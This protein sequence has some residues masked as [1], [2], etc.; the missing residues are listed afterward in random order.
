MVF[1]DVDAAA[2]LAPLEIVWPTVAAL[3][4][5]GVTNWS[6][7]G[8]TT[9]PRFTPATAGV[10][11]GGGLP[12]FPGS[13]SAADDF[14]GADE[15][16]ISTNWS[17]D[18][19]PAAAPSNA[20]RKVGGQLAGWASGVYS[21]SYWN[22]DFFG[23]D[24]YVGATIAALPAGGTDSIVHFGVRLTTIGSGTTDG[25]LVAI[26]RKPG[27]GDNIV[28][29]RIDN[30]VQTVLA[31]DTTSQ[32]AAPGDKYGLKVLG[33]TIVVMANY[34][35]A[36]WAEQASITAPTYTTG[37]RVGIEMYSDVAR[38]DDWFAITVTDDELFP[39]E[40]QPLPVTPVKV[41]FVD[42]PITT[43]GNT[44]DLSRQARRAT[45]SQEPF[46]Q[47]LSAATARESNRY[48]LSQLRSVASGPHDS[49]STAIRH[50]AGFGGPILIITSRVEGAADLALAER[51]SGG[52]LRVLYDPDTADTMAL[53]LNAVALEV[54]GVG[55]MDAPNLP[56]HGH[57]IATYATI[58]G[59]ICSTG[60]VAV[61]ELRAGSGGGGA[62]VTW[63]DV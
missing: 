42:A 10:Q 47:V 58:V 12:P 46:V 45:R 38:L 8:E 59:P 54:K 43:Y 33:S 35:G 32:D 9:L 56:L 25:Y 53:A 39:G 1:A 44:I 16:P 48:V 11:A 2:H 36:G 60:A 18:F 49:L 20:L 19:Y 28:F 50:V 34:G 21:N 13:G 24:L 27:V 52:R 17:S 4:R 26:Q 7:L 14:A 23:P 61:G 3:N 55:R 62:S 5:P 51:M 29:V 63:S 57:D 40:K 6:T 30:S 22:A 41:E 31:T 37:G 15:V